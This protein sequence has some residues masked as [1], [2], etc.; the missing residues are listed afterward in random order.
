MIA[1]LR[2]VAWLTWRQLFS[3]H[4]VWVAVA[5]AGLPL[6]LTVFYRFASEDLEGDRLNFLLIL[7][8]QI[9]LAAL[10]P[11]AAVIFGTTTFGGEQ[12][13]GTLIYLLV[14]P[15]PRWAIVLVKYLVA[16]LATATVISAAMLLAWLS[17]RNAELPA[18]FVASFIAGG[19]A[20]ALLYCAIFTYLGLATKRG[21]IIGL[22]YIIFFENVV[23]RQLEGV[24][25]LS[26]REFATSISKWVGDGLVPTAGYTVPMT[27]VW[28]MG[29]IILAAGL[30]VALRKL[31]RYE[32][33]ERL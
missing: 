3:G 25:S 31:T 33:A 15:V 5:I 2:T 30:A 6:L 14:R 18:R 29:S 1:A 8:S 10:L 20:G 13:D 23:T 11:L 26:V 12:E 24:K 32:L 21:L 16:M 22:I 17:L 28:V 9:V 19:V 4:R 27:T 7:N